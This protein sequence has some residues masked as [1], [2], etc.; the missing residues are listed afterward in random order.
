[1][2]KPYH[3]SAYPKY[4]RLKKKFPPFFRKKLNEAEDQV[5]LNPW[6]GEEKAG[7]LKG[8]RVY[9]FKI[10]DLLILLAYQVNKEEREVIFVAVGGHENFYRDLKQHLRRK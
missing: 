8:I 2:G 5:A 1:M 4:N 3:Q 9:K 10:L 7:E 6:I